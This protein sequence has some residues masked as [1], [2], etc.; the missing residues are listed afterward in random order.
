VFSKRCIKS[1]LLTNHVLI[2]LLRCCLCN[3]PFILFDV[4]AFDETFSAFFL[5][6]SSLTF[7]VSLIHNPLNLSTGLP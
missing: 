4:I 5:Y 1:V 6:L 2:M 7:K 3:E